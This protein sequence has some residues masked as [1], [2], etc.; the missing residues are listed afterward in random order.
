M[1]GAGEVF[2]PIRQSD[3]TVL[4]AVELEAERKGRQM[5]AFGVILSFQLATGLTPYFDR[6]ALRDR[7]YHGSLLSY[8]P[9]C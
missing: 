2:L 8:K 3:K 4:P 5:P 1:A 6:L 7:A 9:D